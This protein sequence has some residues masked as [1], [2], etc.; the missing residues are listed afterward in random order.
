MVVIR[1]RGNG[2]MISSVFNGHQVSVEEDE[3]VLELAGVVMVAQHC[4]YTQSQRT[5]A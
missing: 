2:R 4:E 3:K 5:A 1:G